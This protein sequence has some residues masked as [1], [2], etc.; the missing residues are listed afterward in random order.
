MNL[1][2]DIR[3]GD[4]HVGDEQQQ[5]AHD[6]PQAGG[7]V[8]FIGCVRDYSHNSDH[9]VHALELSHYQGMTEAT[10]ETICQQANARWDL[11]AVRVIH[12]VGKLNAR[13]QIVLVAVAAAHRA[14]A[15][16][17]AEFIMDELKTQATFWKKEIRSDGG[18]WVDMKQSDLQRSARWRKP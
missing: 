12:R 6:C 18:H 7:Q 5:L 16:K 1:Y 2:I 3:E 17:G 14:E 13:D 15:F 11:T 10:I 9:S 4:F 8:L